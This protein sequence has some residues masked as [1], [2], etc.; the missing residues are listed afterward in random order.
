MRPRSLRGHPLKLYLCSMPRHR[1]KVF[2]YLGALLSA[3]C[4]LSIARS[5]TATPAPDDKPYTLNVAVDEVSLTFHAADFHGIPIDDLRLTDLRLLDNNKKPR[6]IL[7]FEVHQ[8]LPVHFG[9]LM[10]TS[11]SMLGH[12]RRNQSIAGEYVTQLLRKQT[13]RAFVMRF[14]SESKVVQDWASDSET[15]TASLRNIDNYF[16][17]RIGG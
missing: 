2:V 11:R 8:N 9:I 16:T 4:I 13:D 7:S 3:S 10:D 5:Q 14:D 17:S 12:F 1:S 15:L 6:Q